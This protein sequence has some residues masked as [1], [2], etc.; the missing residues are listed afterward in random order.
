MGFELLISTNKS[1][2]FNLETAYATVYSYYYKE[3]AE[4]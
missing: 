3:N 4:E 2:S 1:S